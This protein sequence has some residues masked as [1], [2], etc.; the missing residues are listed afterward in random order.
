MARQLERSGAKQAAADMRALAKEI[1]NAAKESGGLMTKLRVGFASLRGGGILGGGGLIPGLANISNIIQGIPQIGQLAGAIIRPLTDAAEEG[2]KLNIVLEQSEIGFSQV[3]GSAEKAREHLMKLQAFGA[4]SPF[5]FEGLLAA[6]RLMTAVGFTIDEQIPKLKVWGN[7]IAAGGQMTEEIVH[8][9]VLAFGQ[10]RM[11]GRVNAQDMLQLTN[12]NIPGWQLLAKAIGKTVAETRN[13][14]QQG[15]LNGKVAVEAITAMMAIDKRFEGMMDRLQ[16]TTGGRLS[17]LQDTV[18]IAQGTATKGLT[19]NLSKTIQHALDRPELLPMLAAQINSILT[20]ISGIIETSVKTVLTPGITTGIV[21]GIRAGKDMVKKALVDFAQDTIIGS[22]KGALGIQSPSTEFIELGYNSAEGYRDG[23]VSG[24]KSITGEIMGG[25]DDLL[26]EVEGHLQRRAKGFV[27]V[28]QKSKA[29]LE[30][31]MQREPD[32]LPK[33]IQMAKARGMNPDHILNVMAVETAGSFNPY[34]RNPTSSASGMIQFMRDTAPTLGTTI[35]AIRKMNATQQL[36]YVFR[37][38][39]QYIKRFGPLDT[40]GKVYA[41]VGTGKVVRD[42]EDVVMRRGQRGYAGNAPTWDRNMDGLIKQSEMA[43]A[44]I[45][46]LGAGITFTVNGQPVAAG[47]PVPVYIANANAVTDNRIGGWRQVPRRLPSHRAVDEAYVNA[48]PPIDTSGTVIIDPE[49]LSTSFDPEVIAKMSVNLRPLTPLIVGAATAAKDLAAEF[50][51]AAKK[52]ADPA[53]GPGQWYKA[54]TAMGSMQERLGQIF[55]SIPENR[56]FMEDMFISLPARFGDIMADS[57]LR[58]EGTMK[59]YFQELKAQAIET[60][61]SIIAE[62]MRQVITR[63]MTQLF[64]KA[65]GKP[66]MDIDT[67][68][69]TGRIVGGWGWLRGLGGFINRIFG[70][71]TQ[72]T[73]AQAASSIAN[74]QANMPLTTTTTIATDLLPKRALG[75]PVFR[76]RPIVVGDHPL[77]HANPEIFTPRSDG[78]VTPISRVLREQASAR[79]GGQHGGTGEFGP[80]TIPIVLVDDE[81]AAREQF[82]TS[83]RAY[84]RKVRRHRKLDIR[85]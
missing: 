63:S 62:M 18:Q 55:D 78:F 19:E 42:D 8:R 38:F 12:A 69:P 31:L 3:A 6:A 2:I 28:Q 48:M 45:A 51:K 44:A 34:I 32:F 79:G 39:D 52:A 61:R 11:A 67:G 80:T 72:Q 54:V 60:F 33:L 47:N 57:F 17:A 29:N 27:S 58:S 84:V 4:A 46:K 5:R 21:E 41:A 16:S 65:L 73:G 25:F 77:G 24:L 85:R 50:E 22:I 56:R 9:V 30:K 40:Q 59:S 71:S 49:T 20:P 14:S 23:L 68:E 81:R 43:Q 70:G 36:E 10:M 15:K 37:Y 13:L 26:D 74:Q 76:G 7:A 66:E 53:L 64:M 75:G 82:N 35:E 1:S 83:D